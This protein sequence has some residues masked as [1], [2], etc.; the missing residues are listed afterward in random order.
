MD[1]VTTSIGVRKKQDAGASMNNQCELDRLMNLFAEPEP[2]PLT[3]EQI[4]DNERL[5]RIKAL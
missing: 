2:E 1:Q 4:L 5:E 3:P